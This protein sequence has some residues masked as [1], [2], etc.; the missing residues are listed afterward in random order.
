MEVEGDTIVPVPSQHRQMELNYDILFKFMSF[1][2]KGSVTSMMRTCSTVYQAGA[3]YI[4]C[5]PV[6]ITDDD[7]LVSFCIFM[8]AQKRA[9]FRSAL[10][11]ST[12]ES[13]MRT[14]REGSS[15]SYGA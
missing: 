7:M 14:P 11:S 5:D 8:L 2:S 9:R 10:S 13:W 4:L 12:P 3:Q 1:S 6:C 15:L